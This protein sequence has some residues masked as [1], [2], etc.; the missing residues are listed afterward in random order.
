MQ[1]G[2][3]N[4]LE[5]SGPL[6]ACNG[7]ALPFFTYIYKEVR[8]KAFLRENIERESSVETRS[9]TKAEPRSCVDFIGIEGQ[10]PL[11]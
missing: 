2:N 5:P 7:T 1:S 6:Q 11:G 9:W 3:F 10:K 8:V 4:F